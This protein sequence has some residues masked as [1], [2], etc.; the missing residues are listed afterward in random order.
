VDVHTF[1]PYWQSIPPSAR[2]PLGAGEVRLTDSANEFT[3]KVNLKERFLPLPPSGATQPGKRVVG[4]ALY[5]WLG[6]V[7]IVNRPLSVPEFM[8]SR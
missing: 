2:S 3:M 5:G 1:S 6:D 7:R 4:P 8:I